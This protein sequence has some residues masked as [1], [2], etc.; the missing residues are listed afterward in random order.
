MAARSK[1]WHEIT[2]FNKNGWCWRI[3][4]CTKGGIKTVADV[5]NVNIHSPF[6]TALVAFADAS[7]FL[8]HY[9]GEQMGGNLEIENVA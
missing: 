5:K 7:E 4:E 9:A 1:T 3:D 8:N 2:V 6:S